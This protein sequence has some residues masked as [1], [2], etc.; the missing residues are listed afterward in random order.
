M[1]NFVLH[2]F[3]AQASAALL[4]SG[5]IMDTNQ[6]LFTPE[7]DKLPNGTFIATGLSGVTQL[8]TYLATYP[9]TTVTR[10]FISDSTVQD[11]ETD[12]GYIRSEH[13]FED[14]LGELGGRSRPQL[15]DEEEDRREDVRHHNTKV[16]FKLKRAARDI[17]APLQ[18]VLDMVAPSLQSFTY[19][20]A[21]SNP[22][23]LYS[24]GHI[25]EHSDPRI[26]A[27]FGRDYPCL[28]HLDVRTRYGDD[29]P[30]VLQHPA[31]YPAI[32]HLHVPIPYHAPPTLASLLV[33][34]PRLTHLLISGV[35]GMDGLPPE[36]NPPDPGQGWT[37]FFKEH[38]LRTPHKLPP[39]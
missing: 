3:L 18:R 29:I 8:D 28:T 19:L 33:N 7:N 14:F 9:D 37:D 36:L 26:A 22:S 21:I 25:G 30:G 16:G 39:L 35:G 23:S 6:T 15:T 1:R 10:L 2:I 31:H 5:A 38:I 17:A 27:L 11:V 24:S 12:Y 32:T 13:D 20:T 4:S 34:F